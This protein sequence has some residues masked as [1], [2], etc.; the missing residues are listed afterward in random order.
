MTFGASNFSRAGAADRPSPSIWGDC[1]LGR[2]NEEGTGV[3]VDT[4]FIAPFADTLA[5]G[6]Q[7]PV[8]DGVLA[9]DCDDD[10]VFSAK[11]SEVNGYQDI[12]TDGDD[13][14]AATL[15]TRP[16]AKIVRRSGNRVWFEVRLELGAVAD[17]G[18]FA[19]LAEEAALSR[20][21]IADNAGA[22]IGESYVGFRV[23]ADDTDAFDAAYKKDA[24]TEVEVLADVTN[25]TAIDSGDRAAVAANTEVK[26]GFYFN[27]REDLKFY[28][29]GVHVAT[30]D[31]DDTLDQSKF[32]G[33]A[34][35][36]KTG[37]AAAQSI[38]IDWVRAAY[39]S[40]DNS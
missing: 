5:L 26:L 9:I 30:Q 18:V 35:S 24:G 1:P 36:I 38:A 33:L 16:F 13:N 20:D 3:F 12:E 37:T 28:V 19:G 7:R 23:L 17:Q 8:L 21:L 34:V 6:E 15:F 31:V 39:E 10:T 27:G 14:D 11:A 40:K 4:T 29:N 25:A 2:L 22:L 32:L